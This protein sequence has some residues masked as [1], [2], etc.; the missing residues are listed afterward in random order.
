MYSMDEFSIGFEFQEINNQVS[1]AKGDYRLQK[2]PIFI[3]KNKDQR[4]LWSVI[5]DNADIEYVLEPFYLPKDKDLLKQAYESMLEFAKITSKNHEQ[6]ITLEEIL[7]N[8]TFNLMLK[9]EKTKKKFWKR[10]YM[11][12]TIKQMIWIYFS[13][14]KNVLWKVS[15]I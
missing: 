12:H 11:Q 7:N 1:W 8:K 3:A 10:L 9:I 6:N 2:Q 5:I 13:I 14:K 15:K 4:T